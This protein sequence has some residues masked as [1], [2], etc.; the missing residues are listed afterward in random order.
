MQIS[1]VLLAFLASVAAA[2]EPPIA[3]RRILVPADRPSTWPQED[4]TFLP[5]ESADFDAWVA[6]ANQPPSTANIAAARYE[7]RLVDNELDEDELVGGRGSWHVELRGNRPALIPL[8]NTSFAFHNAR[9]R[10]GPAEP[11][12]LGWWPSGDGKSAHL[13][14][15][16]APLWRARF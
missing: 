12:R 6:A 8:E 9:W 2:G 13:R 7:V 3:Y 4:A 16:S 11:A 10:G 5:V 1:L 14:A 15:R